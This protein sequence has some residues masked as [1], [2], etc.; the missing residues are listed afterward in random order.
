MDKRKRKRPLT[1]EEV[2][3]IK[4]KKYRGWLKCLYQKFGVR[5]L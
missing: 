4:R 5:S 2:E 3:R 1:K